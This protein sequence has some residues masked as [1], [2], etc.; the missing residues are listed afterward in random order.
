MFIV[1]CLFKSVKFGRLVSE[2]RAM[3]SEQ[4]QD[5]RIIKIAQKLRKLRIEAGYTSYETFAFE[6]D[7]PRV[8][9]GNHEKGSNLTMKSL[10]RLLDIHKVSLS[11]FFSD[12][13]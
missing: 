5:S 6:H 2:L 1:V 13:E 9:Y 4:S 10:L 12:I 8:S 3:K 7:L 11:E